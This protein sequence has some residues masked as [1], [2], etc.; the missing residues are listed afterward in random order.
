MSDMWGAPP[1]VPYGADDPSLNGSGGYTRD[2]YSRDT[3]TSWDSGG[4]GGF[5]GAVDTGLDWLGRGVQAYGR[6]EQARGRPQ[7]RNSGRRAAEPNPLNVRRRRARA[8]LQAM[9]AAAA[10]ERQRLWDINNNSGVSP[11]L[12]GAVVLG[13]LWLGGRK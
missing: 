13:A 4:S 2:D 9:Q 12:I 1:D 5:W 6:F 11:V 10:A 8:E 7:G 3:G